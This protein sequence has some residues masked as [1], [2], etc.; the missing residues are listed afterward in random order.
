MRIQ[1]LLPKVLP[2]DW[3]TIDV[4]GMPNAAAFLY[5]TSSLMGTYEQIRVICSVDEI[6]PGEFWYHV[7]FSRKDRIPSWEDM[8][9][10]KDLFIGRDKL[11]I[12]IFPR[13]QEYVN[14]HPHTLH[15]WRRADG[16]TLP[17]IAPNDIALT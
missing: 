3:T 14:F 1:P 15:L 16:D 11:A 8:R 2:P 4:G 13:E 9:L 10:V 5:S 7:S 6:V 12:Q 17:S